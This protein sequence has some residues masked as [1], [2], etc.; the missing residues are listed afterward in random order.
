MLTEALKELGWSKRHLAE[1]L[2]V[3]PNMVSRWRENPPMYAQRA[4]QE[5]LRYK[6]A[7]DRMTRDLA[8]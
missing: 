4:L 1:W 6:R 2:G 5:R 8:D 3:H 7:I